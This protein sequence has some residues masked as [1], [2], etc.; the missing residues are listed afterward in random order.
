L[1]KFAPIDLKDKLQ[2]VVNSRRN[3]EVLTRI[4]QQLANELQAQY[5]VQYYSEGNFPPNK[6]VKLD[7]KLANPS[8]NKL[9][10]RQGYFVK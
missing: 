3:Q 4:F 10:A 9:R 1:P 2:N 6:Y 8:K 7:V 5:L